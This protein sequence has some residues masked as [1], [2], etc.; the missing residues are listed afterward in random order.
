M[1]ID[2]VRCQ[3]WRTLLNISTEHE[4]SSAGAPELGKKIM[5]IL[6][7]TPWTQSYNEMIMYNPRSSSF[8]LF[9][10]HKY[11]LKTKYFVASS[12]W[13]TQNSCV[14]YPLS[15]T[16]RQPLDSSILSSDCHVSCPCYNSNNVEYHNEHFKL[17]QAVTTNTG[18]RGY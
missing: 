4:Q 15:Q 10:Q 3:I 2:V 6:M 16:A 17:G 7:L 14:S 8:S 18:Y 13:S 11:Q 12:T 9:A 1:K 5:F